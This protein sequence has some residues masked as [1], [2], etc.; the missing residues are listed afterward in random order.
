MRRVRYSL[1]VSAA[2]LAVAEPSFAQMTTEN[3]CGSPEVTAPRQGRH[4]AGDTSADGVL[5]P[6][7]HKFRTMTLSGS[8]N[9]AGKDCDI[10][11]TGVRQDELTTAIGSGGPKHCPDAQNINN[12]ATN[13][14]SVELRGERSGTNGEEETAGGIGTGRYYHVRYSLDDPDSMADKTGEALLLVPHDQGTA[15]LGLWVDEGPLFDSQTC[16]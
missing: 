1:I 5:W 10:N 2:L 14:S 9:S 13:A 11:I 4:S 6:P 3:T 12:S 16:F 7:N 8:V 15:H